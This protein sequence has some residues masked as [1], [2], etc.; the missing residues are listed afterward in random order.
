M[1]F[2]RLLLTTMFLMG[3]TN[4]T[5]QVE[6]LKALL[7]E[8]LFPGVTLKINGSH[9]A[10]GNVAAPT[11][12]IAGFS[13][14]KKVEIFSSSSCDTSSKMGE[15]TTT[16][17]DT[18]TNFIPPALSADGIYYYYAIVTSTAGVASDCS[19]NRAAYTYDATAPTAPTAVTLV[20]TLHNTATP[21]VQVGGVEIGTNVSLYSDAACISPMGSSNGTASAAT[22]NITSNSVIEGTHSYYAKLVD[23]AGNVSACSTN[24]AT[25][26]YDV[27]APAAPSSVALASGTVS[28][29]NNVN[30][31]FDIGG[32]VSGD[33]VKVYGD[34]L[35]LTELASATVSAST[36]TVTVVPALSTD[37]TYP[38]HAIAVDAYGNASACSTA[39][40]SY[41]LDKTAPAKPSALALKTPVS[42]PSNNATPTIT[43]S[44]VV[45]NDVVS[46]YSDAT[47]STQVTSGTV[48]TGTALDLTSPALTVDGSYDFYAQSTDPVGNASGCS[49]V[50]VTYVYDATPP[51]RPTSLALAAPAT[52]PNNNPSPSFTVG[53]SLI[54]GDTVKLYSD[55]SCTTAVSAAT[56]VP[57]GG[58]SVTVAISS[59]LTT[60]A[61]YTYY[62]KAYDPAGNA[63]SCSTA[64][65]SY[66]FDNVAPATPTSIVL[67]SPASSPGNTA[68]PTLQVDGT[69]AG[70]F[71]YV[72]SNAACTTLVATTSA[73]ATSTDVFLSG[74]AEGTYNFYALVKD[75][76]GNASGCTPTPATYTVDLTAPAAPSSIV[77]ISPGSSPGKIATP[78]FQVNGVV[79]GDTVGLY[80]DAAC[81]SQI[82]AGVA[83]GTS[84]LL[85]SGALSGA[86]TY[87]YYAS[88]DDP[89]GNS[90]GCAGPV[91]YT[92][93]NISPTVSSVSSSN[94]DRT[95]GPGSV[96]SITLNMSEVVNVNT[97][98]GSP[99]LT[100]NTTPARTAT[101]VS[102]SGTNQLQFS[103]TSQLGDSSSDLDY[104][105]TTALTLNGALITDTAG[106]NL[107]SSM[108]APGSTSSLSYS[109]SIV[110]SPNPPAVTLLGSPTVRL[111]EGAGAQTM[112]LSM[113]FPATY[114]M[115]VHLQTYGNALTG[116]DYMLSSDV[117]T[118]PTGST[119]ATFTFTPLDNATADI[120]R[121]LMLS[122]DS[123]DGNYYGMM[124][125]ITQKEI[126]LI[127]NDQTQ[128]LAQYLPKSGAMNNHQCVVKTD[129]NMA[130]WGANNQGQLGDNTSGNNKAT[131]VAVTSLSGGVLAS[132]MGTQH[133]CAIKNS[134]GTLWCWGNNSSGQLGIGSTTTKVIPFQVGTY[135]YKKVA[136]GA[137]HTCAIKSDDTLWC[138]G[139]NTARQLGD[140]SAV[141]TQLNPVQVSGSSDRYKEVFA[142][143][144]ETCGILT[145]DD[146]KCWGENTYAQSSGGGAGTISS[147]VATPTIVDAGT[148]YA[149]VAIGSYHAC[150]ITTLGAL[151]CWGLNGS[152]QVGDSTG[153]DKY[154][155]TVIYSANASDVT[156]GSTHTCAVVSGILQ[157]WGANS[158]GQLGVGTTTGAYAPLTVGGS[159]VA[160][161][162]GNAHTCAILSDSSVKCWGMNTYSQLG[163]G[164]E[165]FVKTMSLV[166]TAYASVAQSENHTCGLTTSGA[167]RCWGTNSFGQVG[168]GTQNT[169]SSPVMIIPNGVA[170]IATGP[171][172]SCAVFTS[173]KL[174]C[175]GYNLN[176]RLGDGTTNIR[177]RPTDII[178]SGVSQVSMGSDST[179][180]LMTDG[181]VKCW[182]NNNSY[183]KVGNGSTVTQLT[184]VQ[185]IA[186][187]ATQVSVGSTHACALVSGKVF[188]WGDNTY[189][190]YG[191]FS[192]AFSTTPMDTGVM[193]DKISAGATYTC[194]ISSGD[195]FCWGRNNFNQ[196][197]D[198]T[199]VDKNVPTQ[200]DIGTPY[201]NITASTYHTCGVT[202]GGLL[203]CWGNNSSGQIG[204]S[205]GS[206][207]TTLIASGVASSSLGL[208]G[209]CA[210]MTNG[211]VNCIG[212]NAAGQLGLGN[213]GVLNLPL[214]VFGL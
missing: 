57:A 103:Y 74:L 38:I 34:A 39:T 44:G 135:S 208:V 64:S 106:N 5:P 111:N 181:S 48:T 104:G 153:I 68:N 132:A 84:I 24:F 207:P 8:E 92:Y 185:V 105:S 58:G 119:S 129:G 110:I 125:K 19:K 114:D 35:C 56:T 46:L 137:N 126:Y 169:R 101:Y 123:V 166:E 183:G 160:V 51:S 1:K 148:A 134:D 86:G 90:S 161:S 69:N 37:G 87:N 174:Q 67:S 122:I 211:Y 60:A 157:C 107:S 71:V 202:T 79:A 136:A 32:L 179:C 133:T 75:A 192:N 177:M 28:P 62:A 55:A 139:N 18:T 184:P 109:R 63:S 168:D 13:D 154:I 190:Q 194:G 121:R 155:P 188:C 142:G 16:D 70:D 131:P 209:T 144:N 2:G 91:A 95:Y 196:L 85:T 29:S 30:P 198:L 49:T 197:G 115:T 14:A 180:A 141:S 195:L 81:T 98:G 12:V 158:F 162:A 65:V 102:G 83:T 53:S 163:N 36:M 164:K 42:S 128:Y 96:I 186:S 76:V 15:V 22:V 193:M 167:V 178:A 43:V 156:A 212:G 159:V 33:T 41:V 89:A 59:A 52:S 146:L 50:K 94:A 112:T 214:D 99:T 80:Q 73:T 173:G 213:L 170:Q 113:P 11:I 176:G 182:G 40:V 45:V 66:D 127:D 21:V 25:Y 82:T 200:I 54:A 175:W 151:K 23:A 93:D 210:L 145:T 97:T 31:S 20:T 61:T 203:R 189:G 78:M 138:W 124:G 77:L 72:Y 187:G 130:C 172:G 143:N 26:V 4:S 100:M 206:T 7:G 204:A 17:S 199:A 3:C 117:L 10:I 88:S 147:F 191:N 140:G 118:I 171:F 6:F 150:A 152:G 165:D 108:S 27:T 116:V 9:N 120:P 149:K 201:S 205:G 47:C